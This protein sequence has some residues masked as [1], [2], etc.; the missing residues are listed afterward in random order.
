M[1][2]VR[3]ENIL[4]LHMKSLQNASDV[5]SKIAYDLYLQICAGDLIKFYRLN[6]DLNQ[7][8][9]CIQP[10]INKM[11]D[12]GHENRDLD[13]AIEKIKEEAANRKSNESNAPQDHI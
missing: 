7:I 4:M 10:T 8:L 12:I 13:I 9:Q 1:S 3:K 11:Q 6:Q 5:L 2:H